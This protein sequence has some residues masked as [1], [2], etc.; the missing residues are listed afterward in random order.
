MLGLALCSNIL[1][2]WHL[3]FSTERDGEN[4][5]AILIEITAQQTLPC[6]FVTIPQVITNYILLEGKYY[7]YA[8]K[9]N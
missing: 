6:A 5:I 8:K 9:W 3:H 1:D 4:V 2:F 7:K